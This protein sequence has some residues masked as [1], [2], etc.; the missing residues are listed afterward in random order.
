[1]T[2]GPTSGRLSRRAFLAA[3]AAGVG[4]VAFA[5]VEARASAEA[6]RSSF[7]VQR[8]SR[9]H[10]RTWMAWP[11]SKAIWGPQ[12]AGMQANIALIARTIANY[13]PV[14]MLAN[15]RSVSEARAACGS[16]VHVIGA[17]PIND[18][19]MRDTGPIFRINSAGSLD[20]VGLNFNG[21]GNKQTHANDALVA[22]RVAAYLGAPFTRAGLVSE[23]GAI[24]TDGRAR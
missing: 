16:G 17:I 19:W 23:G 20:A 3:A 4:S 13:E 21:W 5:V 2:S 9:A 8:D 14:F 10:K 18:C 15:S 24:E 12:L 11:D 1:M 7:R 6:G 22:Q